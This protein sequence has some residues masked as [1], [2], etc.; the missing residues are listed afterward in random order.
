SRESW[1]DPRATSELRRWVRFDPEG[2]LAPE[3]G[4]STHCLGLSSLEAAALVLAMRPG[5]WRTAAKVMVAPAIA[6]QLAKE[7]VAAAER[8]P[9]FGVLSCAAKEGDAGEQGAPLLPVWLEATRLHLAIH[10]LFVL[11]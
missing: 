3:D 7:E 1:L 6:A 8:A 4:L 2:A 11:V 9:C 5:L 10:P